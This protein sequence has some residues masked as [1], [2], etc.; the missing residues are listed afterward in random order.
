MD[1]VIEFIGNHAMLA[2]AFVA[3]L[4]MLIW[5]EVRQ[6][7]LGVN[8]VSAAQ[9]I[10][11][12]NDED[13]H[14]LDVREAGERKAGFIADSSHIPLPSLTKRIDEL[15]KY[16]DRPIV[17]YCRSGS[18]SGSACAQLRKAGFENIH[19]LSGGIMAWQ[20]ADLPITR[21]EPKRKKG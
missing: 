21:K 7:A 17:A 10:G 5:H 15:S 20:N 14:F 13:A 4:A 12:L 16:K 2:G 8:S 19:N 3:V 18:R 1:R 11:L 6:R 9:A